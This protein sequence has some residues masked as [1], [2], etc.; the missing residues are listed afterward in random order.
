MILQSSD[1][2]SIL[3]T[4][5]QVEVSVPCIHPAVCHITVHGRS[6]SECRTARMDH[7]SCS[8]PT[9]PNIQFHNSLTAREHTQTESHSCISTL[10]E[11][12]RGAAIV[13]GPIMTAGIS[14][15]FSAWFHICSTALFS[16][17]SAEL[18]I[19]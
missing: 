12:L 8:T 16:L 19:D 14:W 11:H 17:E 2:A 7:E 3:L 10:M 1:E 15:W 13:V 6:A 18:M 5:R 9:S 4:I